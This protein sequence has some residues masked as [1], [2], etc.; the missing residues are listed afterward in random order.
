MKRT[1]TLS[2]AIFLAIFTI[3]Q[4]YQC[5]KADAE[6]MFWDGTNYHA[7]AIDSV[8][9]L[10]DYQTY[11]NF[12]VI[13][14]ETIYTDCFSKDWP[15]WIGRKI[16]VYP[17]GDHLFYNFLFQPVLIKVQNGVG[18]TWTSYS[19]EDGRYITATVTE[20]VEMEFIGI[21]DSL[22]KISFQVMDTMGN[23]V[24]HSINS[25][26]V[27]IS[28]NHGMVK[29]INYKLFPDLSDYMDFE[30]KEYDLCGISNPET[31]IQN[32][33]FSD[34]YN[35]DIGDE[36]HSLK[37]AKM[38]GYY[39]YNFE[40]KIIKTVINKE[41]LNDSTIVIDYK[42]CER[43]QY[44]DYIN[45][46]DT[47]Y[48][49]DDT[50]NETISTE[51]SDYTGLN[52]SPEMF[53]AIGDSN[54]YE[55]QWFTQSNNEEYGKLQKYLID[56]FVSHFPHECI[57][58]IITK[59]KFY[60]G[61]TYLEDLGGPYWHNGEWG[62]EYF[63]GLVYYKKNGEE[64]GIPYD[65]DSLLSGIRVIQ[66]N[67]WHVNI[68][69]NPMHSWT[70]LT[71]ENDEAKEYQLQLYNSM[72]L[73]VKDYRFRSNELMIYR[74]NLPGGMYFFVVSDESKVFSNGKLIIR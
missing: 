1:V 64:W 34:I 28:K 48:F 31:G 32:L 63:H 5:V 65:C 16:D 33:K 41:W 20:K 13:G 42:R 66:D 43:R 67:P 6:Y 26:H 73:L 15:S 51:Y 55:Y 69:P 49:F 72:G 10:P 74:E 21:T 12:P 44:I 58:V 14:A 50:I 30:I 27:W 54:Y 61:E 17:N 22:K 46:F 8:Q 24:S 62:D 39:S 56:G 68:S 59:D 47:V 3:A 57:E 37:F 19:F 70:R 4:D 29:A 38:W 36:F 71:I 9:A 18:D 60:E 25:K 35:F 45:D 7:V 11:Y 40:S 23:P 2:A 52:H 53:Y